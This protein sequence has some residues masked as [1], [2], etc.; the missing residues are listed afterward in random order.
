[1][2]SF[3]EME[4]RTWS[5]SLWSASRPATEGGSP[6]VLGFLLPLLVLVVCIS[7]VDVPRWSRSCVW[8][9]LVLAAE[10]IEGVS[11]GSEW[12]EGVAGPKLPRRQAPGAR[13]ALALVE[14]TVDTVSDAASSL[15][16]SSSVVLWSMRDVV[17]RDL[18]IRRRHSTRLLL[19]AAR[20]RRRSI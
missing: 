13:T 15:A 4:V 19:R 8:V 2:T 14:L 17:D 10:G 3:W 12:S 18:G 16:S 5:K 7:V 11:V 9:I 6:F 20:S 1:M